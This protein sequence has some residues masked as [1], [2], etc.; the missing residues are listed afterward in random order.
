MIT[1]EPCISSVS[2]TKGSTERMLVEGTE[3]SKGTHSIR[4]LSSRALLAEQ[5]V[6]ERSTGPY[7]SM[8]NRV[9]TRTF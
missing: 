6:H 2:R 5:A 1:S 4:D 8:N 9:S 7:P 3:L